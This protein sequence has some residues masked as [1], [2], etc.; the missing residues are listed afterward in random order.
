MTPLPNIPG[1]F[2]V[3]VEDPPWHFTTYSE[4]GR[5]RCPDYETMTLDDLKAMPV[6]DVMADDSIYLMWAIEPMMPE[7]FDLMKARGYVYKTFALTWVKRTKHDKW[8]FGN[9][10]YTRAN[11]E[12][13]L[14]G[15]RG[16]GRPVLDH[17]VPELM[18]AKVREHSRKPDETYTRIER[19]FDGPYLELFARQRRGGAWA[20][21]GNEVDKFGVQA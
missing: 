21:W 10:Y 11:P 6:A 13:L 14:L 12:F 19:L 18:E 3:G 20:S 2:P 15:R 17:G 1:G 8:H 9:G 7:A 5:D 4:E 16:K